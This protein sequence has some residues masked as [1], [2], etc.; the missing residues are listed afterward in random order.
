MKAQRLV[1]VQ[2]LDACE[3]G[4]DNLSSD[5]VGTGTVLVSY[6]AFVKENKHILSIGMDYEPGSGLWRRVSDIPKSLIQNRIE[7][8]VSIKKWA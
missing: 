5:D 4:D 1:V 8:Q 7:V 3:R 6:G 2:W